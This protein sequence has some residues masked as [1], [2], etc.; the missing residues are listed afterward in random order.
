LFHAVILVLARFSFREALNCLRYL[1][2]RSGKT[3]TNMGTELWR[4]ETSCAEGA[5]GGAAPVWARALD[6]VRQAASQNRR[7]NEPLDT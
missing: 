6:H 3:A 2:A 4:A 1:V 7:N 5:C